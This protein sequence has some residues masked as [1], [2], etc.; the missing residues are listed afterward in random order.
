M[1]WYN[2]FFDEHARTV[3]DNAARRVVC[4]HTDTK[5]RREVYER[6]YTQVGLQISEELARLT[7]ELQGKAKTAEAMNSAQGRAALRLALWIQKNKECDT[8]K[9]RK[10]SLGNEYYDGTESDE[11][12]RH[13]N[14]RPTGYR[15]NGKVRRIDTGVHTVTRERYDVTMATDSM[16]YTA[17]YEQDY[18]VLDA[19]G[20]IRSLKKSELIRGKK[21][22]PDYV[23]RRYI[24]DAK[25]CLNNRKVS[26]GKN[27]EPKV[28]E[29]YRQD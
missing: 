18:E 11:D 13:L 4:S 27:V 7:A 8:L 9:P 6:E 21:V 14:T 17:K 12:E 29:W 26:K 10:V 23:T 16:T 22:K 20:K 1:K 5:T 25:Q 28:L 2:F 24:R 15:K 3:A 19:D